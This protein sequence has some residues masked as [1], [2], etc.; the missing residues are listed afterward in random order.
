[1]T[2]VEKAALPVVAGLPT[3]VRLTKRTVDNLPAPDR[4]TT[5]WDA[6]LAG[7]GLRLLP[8]G[9]RTYI[10]QRRTTAGRSIL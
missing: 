10:L 7:F 1:M 6:D 9:A 4:E 3:K 5:V 2:R 8:S